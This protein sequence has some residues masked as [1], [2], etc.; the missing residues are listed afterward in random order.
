MGGGGALYFAAKYA[1]R[2]A[3]VVASG[4]TTVTWAYPFERLRE[5]GIGLLYV[6]GDGDQQTNSHWA[7]LAADYARKRGVD[8]EMLIVKGGDHRTAWRMALKESLDFLLQRRK[9]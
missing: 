3:G 8:A 5:N 4:A 9:P 2:F 6:H 7:Q 1:E